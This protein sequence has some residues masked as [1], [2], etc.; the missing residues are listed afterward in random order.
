MNF[1]EGNFRRLK[2]IKSLKNVLV[3]FWPLSG[4]YNNGQPL[5]VLN[6]VI[7]SDMYVKKI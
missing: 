3:S 5:E 7:F 1:V 4:R 2:C 6:A